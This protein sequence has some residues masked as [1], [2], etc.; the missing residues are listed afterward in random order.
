MNN[1]YFLY[2]TS[3]VH[4]INLPWLDDLQTIYQKDSQLTFNIQALKILRKKIELYSLIIKREFKR[5][6]W[7]ETL[8]SHANS[9]Y[10]AVFRQVWIDYPASFFFLNLQIKFFLVPVLRKIMLF[11][12]GAAVFYNF[13]ELEHKMICLTNEPEFIFVNINVK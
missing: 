12:I 8:R 1:Q 3:G 4:C 11:I 6:W 13:A 5:V 10:Q 9:L 2:H 7:A